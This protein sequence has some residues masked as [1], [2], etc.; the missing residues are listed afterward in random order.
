MLSKERP[1]LSVTLVFVKVSMKRPLQHGHSLAG[2][3]AIMKSKASKDEEVLS[4]VALSPA[5]S[6]RLWL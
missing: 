6:Q 2:G 5:T 1:P 3:A 4:A